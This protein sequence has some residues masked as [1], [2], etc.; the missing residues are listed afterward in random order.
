MLTRDDLEAI[1]ADVRGRVHVACDEAH[2]HSALAGCINM[3][4][5][6]SELAVTVCQL[7]EHLNRLDTALVD[8]V[9]KGA[10]DRGV[11]EAAA[12]VRKHREAELVRRFAQAILHGD[13][14]HR[15]WLLEAAELFA[16]GEPLPPPPTPKGGG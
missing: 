3:N 13:A 16:E 10:L 5:G 9:V 14:E 6:E 15:E 4:K 12:D 11:F 2:A 8:I 1:L 7:G